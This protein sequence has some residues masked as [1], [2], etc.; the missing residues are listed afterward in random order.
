MT[1]E[2]KQYAVGA[3][4]VALLVIVVVALQMN[5]KSA[6]PIPSGENTN[7]M[8]GATSTPPSATDEPAAAPTAPAPKPVDPA[9][10][11]AKAL[12]DYKGRLIQ[13]SAT[14][15]MTPSQVTFKNGTSVMFD[16]RG[17]NAITIRLGE[18]PFTIKALDYTLIKVTSKTLPNTVS[19]DCGASF[20]V[21]RILLQ[22]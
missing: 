11:Y 7:T 10:T 16:N 8:P 12:V 21:G 6:G 1:N 22:Q 15:Q 14:C 4:V 5:Q 17:P 9:V 20:N 18:T 19:V 13:F 2:Q 3:G